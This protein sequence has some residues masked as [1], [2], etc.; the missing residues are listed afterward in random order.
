LKTDQGAMN[1]DTLTTRLFRFARKPF[2]KQYISLAIKLQDHFP[3]VPI[4]VRLAFGA[5]WLAGTSALDRALLFDGFENA[6]LLFVQR[7]LKPGMTVF[8]MGAHHGL[9]TMLASKVTGSEG[10]VY[11]FE[12][13]PRERTRLKRN[14]SLN[15]CKNV[16]VISAA[17]GRNA[18]RAT[19]HLV[20][21]SEDGCNSLRTPN[22]A[23]PTI[24]VEVEVLTLDVFLRQS[25]VGRIDFA[26]MD[27][28]GAE[29]SLL[30]GASD[31]FASAERPVILAE[32]SDVRTGPWGYAAS[33]IIEWLAKRGYEWF[34]LTETGSLK[35]SKTNRAFHDHNL[36]AVPAEKIEKTRDL[37]EES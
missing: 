15:R 13:S 27:V 23:Q 9:Y 26:K 8:D 31:L 36:V 18:G 6:E 10:R 33:E 2:S 16:H 32:I 7:F 29:L 35:R 19:L 12:P 4:P 17:L 34:E 1:S 30:E 3:S 24:P 28:E 5:W 22:V 25:E 11:A 21:G 20:D 37:I 14:L